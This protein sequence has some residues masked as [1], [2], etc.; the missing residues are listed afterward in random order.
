MH[1]KDYDVIISGCGPAGAL[2][3]YLLAQSSVKILILEKEQFPRYKTCAGGLQHRA[4]KLIPFDISPVIERVISGIYFSFKNQNNILRKY[5]SPIIYTVKRPGFD[6][7]LAQKAAQKGCEIKFGKKVTG[8]EVFSNYVIV[9]TACKDYRA[10]ILAGAD[11]ARGAVHRQIMQESSCRK[12]LGYEV[13]ISAGT[14]SV[15]TD[16]LKDEAGLN[17][18]MIYKD[19]SGNKFDFTDNLRLDFGGVKRG[20]CWVFPK[21]D[22]LSCGIGAPFGD[23][24]SLKPYFN[25]FLEK[26]NSYETAGNIKSAK[27]YAHTIPVMDKDTKF[28][29]ERVATIGDAAC[30][31]DGFTGEG[32]YN[33]FR[34]AIILKECIMEAFDLSD[35]SFSNYYGKINDSIYKE[36]KY[37]MLFT[38]AFYASIKFFYKLVTENSRIFSSCCRILRGE[39]SYADALKK[40]EFFKF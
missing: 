13:E 40:L 25:L 35:F 22:I 36:I 16:G 1:D 18:E 15:N 5:G 21:S 10:K 19:K 39:R 33:C 30:L 28:C 31:A 6:N 23:V 24:K 26:F 17:Q 2:L 9:K 8:Y 27:I 32:L 37:S 7:F 12:I 38:R 11:G 34:S 29:A 20:Y 14:K 4:A 3:G